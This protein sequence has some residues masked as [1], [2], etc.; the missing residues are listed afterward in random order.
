MNTTDNHF[1]MLI[2]EDDPDVGAGLQEFFEI[3]G[4]EVERAHDGEDALEKLREKPDYDIVLLDVMLPKKSGFDV[5]QESQDMNVS[6]PVLMITGRGEQENVLKGFGLGAQDYVIKPFDADELA[7]RVRAILVRTQ[8]P[9]KAPMDVMEVGDVLIN[10]STHTATRNQEPIAFT[11]LEYDILRYLITNRN[12]VVTR[13]QLLR[14]V[15]GISQDIETRTID[16]HV[17]SL[18]KKLENDPARP[19]HIETVYGIGYRYNG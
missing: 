5:L 3:Q 13:K 4:Y 9:N 10:F 15:W 19:E 14:D 6:A 8:P 2:V 7:A 1:S 11:A 17:A 16:R 18:R 12:H